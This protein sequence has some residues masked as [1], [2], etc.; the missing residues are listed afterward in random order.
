MTAAVFVDTNLIVYTR[1]RRFAEKR[2]EAE[3][4]LELLWSE[5]RART[6]MQVL[7]E[8][9]T[10]VT[11]KLKPGLSAELAREDV[12]LL[13]SWNPQ[14]IDARLVSRAFDIEMRHRLDW[15][16]CLIVAA[17]QMQGCV[18]LLT[19][20]MQDGADYGGVIIR[21]PFILRVSEEHTAYAPVTAISSRHRGRGRP[22]KSPP[23]STAA[24]S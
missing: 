10:T 5:Q 12:Q 6:S 4:W 1:D 23:R 13:L 21:N 20:D 8:Y 3:K 14:P 7:N 19:E 9:Y 15:W 2:A 24:S 16:D 18:L 11:R 22:R 17:A